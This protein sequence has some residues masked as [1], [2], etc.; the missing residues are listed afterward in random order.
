ML[1][2]V[3]TYFRYDPRQS[4]Y[5]TVTLHQCDVS[6]TAVH[7][8]VRQDITAGVTQCDVLTVLVCLAVQ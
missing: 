7:N 6:K 1:K 4:V 2:R 3:K 8:C 5:Q